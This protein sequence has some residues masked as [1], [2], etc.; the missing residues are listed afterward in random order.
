MLRVPRVVG[1]QLAYL[2]FIAAEFG[3]WVAVLVYAYEAT[4]PLSVGVVAVAQLIPAAL[5]APVVATIGEHFARDRQMAEIGPREFRRVVRRAALDDHRFDIVATLR[6]I[7]LER[8]PSVEQVGH[9]QPAR[10]D[11]VEGEVRRE[12]A[13]RVVGLGVLRRDEP[14]HE[15]L[16]A[17]NLAPWV[18]QW[19]M[20]DL[21]ATVHHGEQ[22]R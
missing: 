20:S 8:I 11:D 21:P 3:A 17:H 19:T 6:R 12:P 1:V 9:G 13:R 15:P 7:L 22:S 10:R 4:G 5:L 14:E 16:H 2:A 18:L